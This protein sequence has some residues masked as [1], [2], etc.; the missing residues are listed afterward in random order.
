MKRKQTWRS[1]VSAFGHSCTSSIEQSKVISH[2]SENVI[3][4]YTYIDQ[5]NAEQDTFT[6]MCMNVKRIFKTQ[7][8]MLG[9]GKYSLTAQILEITDFKGLYL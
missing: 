5:Q 7:G 2:W 3:G 9:E 1:S 6:N 4:K 8:L